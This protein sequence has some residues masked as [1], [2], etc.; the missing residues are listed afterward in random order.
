MYVNIYLPYVLPYL[1]SSNSTKMKIVFTYDGQTLADYDKTSVTISCCEGTFLAKAIKKL[2]V[3]T[4][5]FL[6]IMVPCSV[7]GLAMDL[8]SMSAK[9]S[10]LAT[11]KTEKKMSISE[12]AAEREQQFRKR[13]EQDRT[14]IQAEGE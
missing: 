10:Q 13:I 8:S 4:S 11:Y 12:L 5:T 7:E 9:V 6:L 2:T 3:L 1:C 14:R